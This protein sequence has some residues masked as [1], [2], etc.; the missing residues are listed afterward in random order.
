MKIKNLKIQGKM[1]TN[2]EQ[3]AIKGGRGCGCGGGGSNGNPS[4]K[5][6]CYAC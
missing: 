6:P 5:S 3:K 2:K 1:L 4:T